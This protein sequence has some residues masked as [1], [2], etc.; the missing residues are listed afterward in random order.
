MERVR[1]RSFLVSDQAWSAGLYSA[2]GLRQLY[3][4]IAMQVIK[5]AI[6]TKRE[7]NALLAAR[8]RAE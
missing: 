3:Q 8:V 7:Q 4:L 1:P 6:M 5:V 2:D